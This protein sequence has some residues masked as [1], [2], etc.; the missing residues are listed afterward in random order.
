MVKMKGLPSPVSCL[1]N[2]QTNKKPG[3]L[4]LLSTSHSELFFHQIF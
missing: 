2:K 1:K 4:V 3:I